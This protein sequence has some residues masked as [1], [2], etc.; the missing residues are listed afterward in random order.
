MG[1][2]YY[3]NFGDGE[4]IYFS[5]PNGW[6]SVQFIQSEKENKSAT[7]LN[8]LLQKA[9]SQ[10]TDAP[11]LSELAS[12]AK[13]AVIIVDDVT[14]PTPLAEIC[15]ILIP[16]LEEGGLSLEDLTFVVALGSHA[17]MSLD[18]LEQKVGK[19]I[20]SSSQVIQHDCWGPDLLPAATLSSGR[21]V[22]IN[23][24]V[25]KADLKI[26]LGSILPH[27]MAGF[28]GAKMIMPGVADFE[29]IKEHH[30]THMVHP[31]SA[32]GNINGNPF[33]EEILTVTRMVGLD[34]I[35]RCIFNHEG[36]VVDVVAGEFES[37]FTKGVE[38]SLSNLGYR[39]DRKVDVSISCTFPFVRGPQMIKALA[40]PSIVT[41]ERGAIMLVAPLPEP[42]PSG[43]L[44]AFLEIREKSNNN[45]LEYAKAALS[46]GEPVLPDRAVDFN[47]AI[48]STVRR[49][50]ERKVFLV[51]QK[52][53]QEEA[54]LMGFEYASSVEEGLGQLGEAYPD[55]DVAIFPSGGL[56]I[57]VTDV[58]SSK[59]SLQVSGAQ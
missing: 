34:F 5:L 45:P 23:P 21:A 42:L 38:L 25:A 24:T 37:A 4:R 6:K 19:A 46:R 53:S 31:L 20:L 1:Q 18:Q 10:P 14:R 57:P 7:S 33:Y 52:V 36:G 40:P 58:R 56:V 47:M 17:P 32:L 39:F 8:E 54:S 22:K 13:K 48:I 49:T 2:Q 59:N 28:G 26:S 11:S 51:S 27:S 41:R 12:K 43:F 50:A 55:A 15:E 30:I 29:S 3:L 9:L 35:L 44:D 16:Y